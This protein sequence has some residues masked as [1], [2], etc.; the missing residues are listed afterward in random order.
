MKILVHNKNSDSAGL[1][2]RFVKEKHKVLWYTE[3]PFYRNALR[4]MGVEHVDSMT[5]GV[6]EKPDFVLFDREGN[7]DLADRL[8]KAGLNVCC[9][10]AMADKMELDR[11]FGL[12]LM[13]D[14][15]IKIPKTEHFSNLQEAVA[16]VKKN[17]N[18]YAIKVDGNVGANSSYVSKD[19]K[20]MLDYLA[21]QDE[22]GKIKKGSKFV[23]QEVV[24]GV[25]ISTE[26]WFANGKPIQPYNSTFETKKFMPGDLGPNTGCE[27]SAMFP[28]VGSGVPRMVQKTIAKIFPF[29]EKQKWSGPLDINCIVSE[30]D[31]EPYGLEWTVRLGYSAIYAMAASIEDGLGEF[32]YGIA[33]GNIKRIPFKH[34][35][36]TALRLSIPPYPYENPADDKVEESLYEAVAGLRVVAPNSPGWW[37]LDV[38]K[39]SKGRLITSGGSGTV[40]ECTGTGET[41]Y[42]AWKK[43]QKV[44]EEVE[45]PGKMGRYIDGSERAFKD[46]TKIKGW[47]YDIPKP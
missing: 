46:A 18:A 15:G 26:V 44:F 9:A 42:Q 3:L 38:E 30:K 36:A 12:D 31:H 40:G 19:D 13:K 2:L 23:L 22:Q 29:M 8:K 11:K 32:F 21:Y 43:S 4:N 39:D 16:Y 34:T 41:I 14:N 45:V 27:T 7:G 28:Y 24:K 10:N 6:K 35:W 37:P 1:A 47:G 17:P 25:E 33:S 5:A 20:D